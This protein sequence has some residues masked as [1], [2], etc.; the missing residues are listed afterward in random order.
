MS[1]NILKQVPHEEFANLLSLIG[2]SVRL[3]ILATLGVQEACVCHLETILGMRQAVLSQHL[4]ILRKANLVNS[5]REGRNIFYSL[6]N[7]GLL[8]SLQQ[9]GSAAGYDLKM[10]TS[11]PCSPVTGCPCPMCNPE[12]EPAQTCQSAR[13]ARKP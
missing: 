8:V 5:R 6:A 7:P 3:Q 10:F 9:L 1:S 13:K 2:Q 4:M 11:I 12:M